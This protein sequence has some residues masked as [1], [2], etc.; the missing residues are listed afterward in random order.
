M[1]GCEEFQAEENV[2][3]KKLCGVKELAKSRE[4]SK[5]QRGCLVM[6]QVTG[7]MSPWILTLIISYQEAL[8]K[9]MRLICK[10]LI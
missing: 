7:L 10:G 6:K 9:R 8:S 3:R 5:G 1:S 4:H 2:S